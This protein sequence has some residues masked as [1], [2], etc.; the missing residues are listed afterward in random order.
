GLGG[1]GERERVVWQPAAH[2]DASAVRI[3]EARRAV[4]RL[5]QDR[6]ITAVEERVR[7]C[8]GGFADA[9]DDHL[10]RDGVE[11]HRASSVI[12]RLPKSSTVRAWPGS[13]T[14]VESHCSPM[15]GPAMRSPASRRARSYRYAL[16]NSALVRS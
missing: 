6:R 11:L 7:H 15:A 13:T 12:R 8:G 14:V 4:M 2:H 16:A 9:A 5:A 1:R 3:A 10:G